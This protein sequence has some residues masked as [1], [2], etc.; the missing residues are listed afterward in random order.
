ME[1][2]IANLSMSLDGY[3]AGPND[4]A[5]N[6]LGDGGERLH[7]WMYDGVG[8]SGRRGLADGQ[9]TSNT[10]VRDELFAHTGAF[11]MGSRV[12]DYG[13]EPWGD[14]PPFHAP[15][16]VLTHGARDA[17]IRGRPNLPEAE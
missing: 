6:P 3:I 10:E 15:V 1:I 14:N 17:L 8:W 13:V 7:E 12:F 4:G 16:F 9:P 5:E 11:V 2:L